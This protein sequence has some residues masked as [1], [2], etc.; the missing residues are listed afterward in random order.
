MKVI[1]AG[2]RGLD[3][4]EPIMHELPNYDITEVVSGH[5]MGPDRIGEMYARIHDIPVKKFLPNWALGKGAALMRNTDMADYAD[6]ALVFWDGF[7]NGAQ[8]MIIKMRTRG[9]PVIVYKLDW[10]VVSYVDGK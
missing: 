4:P 2:S 8:D 9:K 5:A 1:I 10:D 6:E 3:V 7:S